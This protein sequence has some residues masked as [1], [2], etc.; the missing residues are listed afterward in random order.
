MYRPK[1]FEIADDAEMLD[2]IRAN[3]FAVLVTQGQINPP[4]VNLHQP[5]MDQ[6]TECQN[7]R[8]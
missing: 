2:L 4:P 5:H 7:T 8:R 6:K 3:G 1:Q